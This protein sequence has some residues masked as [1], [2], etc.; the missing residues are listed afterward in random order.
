MYLLYFFAYKP[1]LLIGI[2]KLWFQICRFFLWCYKWS[3]CPFAFNLIYA[4]YPISYS[5][6]KIYISCY[7]FYF[8]SMVLGKKPPFPNFEYLHKIFNNLWLHCT[9]RKNFLLYRNTKTF[10][11]WENQLNSITWCTFTA[12]SAILF[13][14]SYIVCGYMASS[15]KNDFVAVIGYFFVISWCIMILDCF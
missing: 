7:Q 1:P 14:C 13:N 12:L 4:Q 3:H 11:P 8:G 5:T 2:E 6:A 15:K 10:F 9:T